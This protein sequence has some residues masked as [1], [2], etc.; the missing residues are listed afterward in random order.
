MKP[1]ALRL[2]VWTVCIALSLA[3]LALYLQ[4]SFAVM[5]AQ[6]LWACF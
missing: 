6:Q 4:P 3:V 1:W 2:T 5:L